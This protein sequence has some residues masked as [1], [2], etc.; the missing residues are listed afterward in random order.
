MAEE[1]RLGVDVGGTFTD[2]VLLGSDGT[3]IPKKVL[4]SVPDYSTAIKAGVLELLKDTDSEASE[5]GEYSHGATV[6]TNAIITRKGALTGLI[7][8][9]GFRDVL[10]IRRMRMH[11]LYDIN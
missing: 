5:I 2:V 7:T 4:S 6:A 10:E 3:A 1:M 8:T 9:K 11:K